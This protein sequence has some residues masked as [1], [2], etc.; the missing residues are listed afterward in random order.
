MGVRWFCGAVGMSD[1]NGVDVKTAGI[2]LA[3]LALLVGGGHFLYDTFVDKTPI[4]VDIRF[5]NQCDLPD[6]VFV[7]KLLP[8]GPRATLAGGR[9]RIRAVPGQRIRLVAND[10]A[11]RDFG[12]EGQEVRAAPQVTLV[13]NCETNKAALDSLKKIGK[14]E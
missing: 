4:D 10:V 14:R 1:Q 6:S 2:F 12:F 5:V 9:G 13:A 7:A 8:D 11:F 3:V